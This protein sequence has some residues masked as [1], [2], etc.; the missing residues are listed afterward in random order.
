MPCHGQ[1]DPPP[2]GGRAR[3]LVPRDFPPWCRA[4]GK[5]RGRGHHRL[6]LQAA[7]APRGTAALGRPDA[8]KRAER[9]PDATLVRTGET[10]AAAVWGTHGP[11]HLRMVEAVRARGLARMANEGDGGLAAVSAPVPEADGVRLRLA[12][13]VFG[14]VGRLNTAPHGPAALVVEAARPLAVELRGQPTAN[15]A[16]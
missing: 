1:P 11:T 10:V 2:G 12:L 7:D 3:W 9:A 6:Q 8:L 4:G 15:G 16:R 13:T 14:R 5:G